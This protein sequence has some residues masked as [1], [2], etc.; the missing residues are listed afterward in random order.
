MNTYGTCEVCGEDLGDDSSTFHT[1][2]SGGDVHAHCCQDCW[3]DRRYKISGLPAG[4]F[5]IITRSAS[6]AVQ[7]F[8]LYAG[9]LSVPVQVEDVRSRECSPVGAAWEACQS[10]VKLEVI[11]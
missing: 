3:V 6:D 7:T 11:A 9:S 2:E 1:G 4:V 8:N 5:D 10:G